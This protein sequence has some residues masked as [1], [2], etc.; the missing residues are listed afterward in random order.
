MPPVYGRLVPFCAVVMANSIN[1]PMMRSREFVEGIDL[2]DEE[3]NVVGKSKKVAQIAI[4]QVV[5]SRVGMA[6]PYM[7][8]N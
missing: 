7:G 1:I 3:G 8:N 2:M 4:P 6:T 5:I